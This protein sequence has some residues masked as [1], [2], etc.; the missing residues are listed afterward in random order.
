MVVDAASKY[1]T[2]YGILGADKEQT[3]DRADAART[4][5]RDG[6]V[7]SASENLCRMQQPASTVLLSSDFST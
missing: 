7:S 5:M 4:R 2:V 1:G 6:L 3:P